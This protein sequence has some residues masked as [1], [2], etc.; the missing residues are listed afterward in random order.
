MGHATRWTVPC[1]LTLSTACTG[2]AAGPQVAVS[3]PMP[4]TRDSAWVRAKRALQS[5]VFTIGAED[6]INGRIAGMRY[7]SSTA[8]V[9]TAAACRVQLSLIIA[10]KG[11]GG[12]LVDTS[13]WIAPTSM[14]SSRGV[15]EQDREQTLERIR[16]TIVPPPTAQ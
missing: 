9:G 8:K 2:L 16:L 6:S 12:A 3:A 4:V 13:R 10:S 1:L 5:E 11:G 15:C 7:P 14:A